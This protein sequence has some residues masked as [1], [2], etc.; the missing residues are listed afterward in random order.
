LRFPIRLLT[1]AALATRATGVSGGYQMQRHA[2]P[3]GLIGE[4][5]AQL[6]EGPGMPLVAMFRANRS[7]FANPRK[8]FESQCLARYDGFHDQGFADAVIHVPLKTALTARVLSEAALRVL[9]IHLLQAL[10]AGMVALAGLFD[11]RA[12]KGFTRAISRQIDDAQVNTQPPAVWRLLIWRLLIWRLLIWRLPALGDMQIIDAAPPNQISATNSPCGVYQHLVLAR[13]KHQTA[14]DTP[15][16]GVQRDSIETHQAI[17]ARIVADAPSW[18]KSRTGITVPG[19]HRFE[20]FNSLGSGTDCQLRAQAVV[21]ARFAIDPMMGGVGVGVGV[22]D[23][24]IPADL[25]NP[26]RGL[27]EGVLRC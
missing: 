1:M 15:M 4:K 12:A 23:A 10:T 26:G 7:P 20:S 3:C 9:R 22:G 21:P 14:D 19:L 5:L 6:G 24:L 17:G 13:A 18:P 25:R 27:V 2:C 8:V 16:L 11:S